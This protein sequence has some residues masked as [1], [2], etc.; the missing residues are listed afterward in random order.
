MTAELGTQAMLVD[1]A[2]STANDLSAT[3]AWRPVEQE[4]RRGKVKALTIDLPCNT[5][6]RARRAPP[7][8]RMPK[9]LRGDGPGELWGLKGLPEKDQAK[10]AAANRMTREAFR[11]IKV[12]DSLS[13][14][15]FLENPRKSRLWQT[16][17]IKNLLKSASTQIVNSSMCQYGTQWRKDT[18]LL[19]FGLP[20]GSVVLDVCQGRRGKCSRTHRAH[21]NL[22]GIQG[23]HFTTAQAQV[24]PRGFA[25]AIMPTML[26][27]TA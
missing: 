18:R 9:P 14:P 8:S 23:K 15:G 2:D 17:G 20:K 26:R 7:W 16:R 12:A 3:R 19:V 11:A 24:Y 25:L 21:L 10:V 13:I 22:T 5:W 1:L 4:L 27:A 6:S